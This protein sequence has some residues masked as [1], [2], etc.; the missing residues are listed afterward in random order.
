MKMT[1]QTHGAAAFMTSLR[2]G[3]RHGSFQHGASRDR[4]LTPRR[5]DVVTA[6]GHLHYRLAASRD[7]CYHCRRPIRMKRLH[8]CSR[9]GIR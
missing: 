7:I 2:N 9:S 3:P 1:G 4:S 8:A 5:A 6:R